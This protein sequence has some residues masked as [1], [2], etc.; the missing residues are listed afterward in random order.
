MN[1]IN[2]MV[3]YVMYPY[4]PFQCMMHLS[5]RQFHTAI[6]SECCIHQVC[7][8][9]SIKFK[10]EWYMIIRQTCIN[11]DIYPLMHILRTLL[12]KI[13]S[14]LTC[15]LPMWIQSISHTLCFQ[16]WCNVMQF[17]SQH[18]PKCYCY[19]PFTCEKI[20]H[21][22]TQLMGPFLDNT[23]RVSLVTFHNL[24]AYLIHKPIHTVSSSGSCIKRCYTL[25]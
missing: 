25:P 7:I 9:Y 2:C 4:C 12:L 17:L 18:M 20:Y 11:E 21:I 10:Y 22:L 23:L 1:G 16:K 24:C 6:R 19:S 8:I 13:I 14:V 15:S 3:C 5:N